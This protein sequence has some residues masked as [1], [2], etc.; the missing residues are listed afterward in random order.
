MEGNMSATKLGL[1]LG[2][3]FRL[4][5]DKI[6]FSLWATSQLGI[7]ADLMNTSIITDLETPVERRHKFV[8]SLLMITMWR[9][10]HKDANK[11]WVKLHTTSVQCQL[12]EHKTPLTVQNTVSK[13]LQQGYGLHF[14]RYG[15]KL[16][17]SWSGSSFL[18]KVT[19]P[20]LPNTET[21]I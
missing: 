5:T 2:Q 4:S 11:S 15:S 12:H 19:L 1:W 17:V 7:S 20:S 3:G 6:E 18:S 13:I 8:Q 10:W 21:D 16:Q 14:G 9:L